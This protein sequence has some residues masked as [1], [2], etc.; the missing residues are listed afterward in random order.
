MIGQMKRMKKRKKIRKLKRTKMTTNGERVV[1]N[2][3]KLTMMKSM[4]AKMGIA[5]WIVIVTGTHE[6]KKD[7][8]P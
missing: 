8:K 5:F 4:K 6:I 2:Q 7:L 1:T 3:I